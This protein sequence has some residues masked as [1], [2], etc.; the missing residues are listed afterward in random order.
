M[1]TVAHHADAH[2]ASKFNRSLIQSNPRYQQ[3][4]SAEQAWLWTMAALTARREGARYSANKG[5]V[6]R[7]CDPD[8]IVKCLDGLYRQQRIT[9][10]HARVLRLWG[11]RQTA[12]SPVV[13]IER[14][15]HQLWVEALSKLDWPLRV[16]GIIA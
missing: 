1:P 2:I 6:S 11:E 4:D 9:L 12:P 8:D 3:F 7:P 16:K 14:H 15:D 10:A 13:A 5:L